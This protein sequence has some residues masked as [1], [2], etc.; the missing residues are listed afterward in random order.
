MCCTFR[1]L[2]FYL[3][4]S[5][6]GGLLGCACDAVSVVRV[7]LSAVV[8]L[9]EHHSLFQSLQSGPPRYQGIRHGNVP[10]DQ[11]VSADFS[12]TPLEIAHGLRTNDVLRFQRN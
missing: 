2:V 6:C 12:P 4:G 10:V 11:G 3:V 9:Y 5:L 8:D 1:V 7:S